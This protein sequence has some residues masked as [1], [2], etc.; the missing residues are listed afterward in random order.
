MYLQH[1]GLDRS[2]FATHREAP[3]P[4]DSLSEAAARA[5]YLVAEQRRIGVLLGDRGWGKTTTLGVVEGEQRAK[6]VAVARI[7]SVGLTARELLWRVAQGLGASPDGA[8]MPMQLW[9]RIEDQLAQNR[10]QE[11]A[12]LLLVDDVDELGPDAEQTLVRLARLELDAQARWTLLL[13]TSSKSLSRLGQSL[14]HLIDLRVDL[15]PWSI[16]DTIGYIQASLVDAGRM[17]PVFT[18]EGLTQLQELTAGV[19]RHVVRLAD[20]ALLAGASQ[21]AHQVDAI[22]IEQAFNE[23][24]WSPVAEP[25]VA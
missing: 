13:A 25:A 17:E 3:Y 4:T 23:T 14:L 6:G 7:D 24:K 12:S 9:R 19:P 2:P 18:D 11:R 16:D 21:Q 8:D 1:W 22:M 20:F 10:W 15:S 5:D